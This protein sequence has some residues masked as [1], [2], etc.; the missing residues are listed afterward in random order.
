MDCKECRE[1]HTQVPFVVFE[2]AKVTLEGT[3]KRLWIAL[4][5]LIV[6]L[7]AS[8]GAWIYHESQHADAQTCIEAEQEAAYGDNYA[9][10][11]DYNGETACQNNNAAEGAQDWR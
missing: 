1:R 11:G 5:L 4:I 2:S 10:G 3:I 8:N 7:C 9:I 6:L